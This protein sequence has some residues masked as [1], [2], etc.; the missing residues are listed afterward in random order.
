MTRNK[1]SHVVSSNLWNTDIK[2]WKFLLLREKRRVFVAAIPIF[3]L[4]VLIQTFLIYFE[5]RILFVVRPTQELFTHLETSP[6]P[7][8]DCKFWPM[9]GTYG[10]WARTDIGLFSVSHLLWHKVSVYKSHLRRP[11][12]LTLI[13]SV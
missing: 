8:N 2:I 5:L 1:K 9:L 10:Q 7:V 4:R 12:T 3:S 13:S 11:M 6:L